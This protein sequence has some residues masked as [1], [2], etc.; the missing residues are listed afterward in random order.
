[1]LSSP[2]AV[3]ATP[4][5]K[6]L[7]KA[8]GV[9]AAAQASYTIGR[10]LHS[11]WRART[12]YAVTVRSD[13]DIYLDVHAWLLDRLPPGRHRALQARSSRTAA[14]DGPV[15]CD[16][17][18]SGATPARLLLSYDDRREQL[19][20]VDG[21]R[22]KVVV[23][24]ASDGPAQEGRRRL[25]PDTITLSARTEAGQQVIVDTLQRILDDRTK[26]HRRPVLWMLA[27]WG[28]WSK[29]RDLPLR[30]LDSVILRPGQVERLRDDLGTFL[31]AEE[32]Y[33][34]R[35][36]PWHRGYLLH[37]QPGTGKTSIAKALANHFGMDIWYAPLGDLTKDTNL[38]SLLSEVRPRSILLLEDVDSFH[39]ATERVGEANQVSMSGLLNALDG[40][41]TP[42]GLV[43][44]MTTNRRE[45][46][47][48]AVL[49]PGRVDLA[50][51]IGLP[52]AE[53]AGRL[54]A[55]FYDRAPT[56]AIDPRGL[57]TAALTEV[58]KRHMDD[59]AAAEA[60]LRGAARLSTSLARA[61]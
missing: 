39:A 44:I 28:G 30:D 57:S 4:A 29:R 55:H 24:R 14:H 41:A 48:D 13:D 23:E 26:S 54:F 46:I 19:I 37:G 38:L 50:E 58:F 5:P 52:D 9:Y 35:G 51:E 10:E 11:W 40:V 32:R 47:D 2:K 17:D 61:V 59:P 25:D 56:G 34:R 16:G 49:R 12:T 53:Q 8:A 36:I 15:P 43:T 18:P 31:A 22:I 21:H 1:M 42:H 27:P 45:V 3:P 7:G 60:D 20:T 6:L 33:V